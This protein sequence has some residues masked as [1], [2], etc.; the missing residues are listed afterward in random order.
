MLTIFYNEKYNIFK[1]K[2][3]KNYAGQSLFFE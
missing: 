2:E 1:V 3:M